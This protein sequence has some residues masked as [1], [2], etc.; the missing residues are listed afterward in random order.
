[1][2]KQVTPLFEYYRNITK[3]WTEI[4]SGLMVQ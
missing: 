4:P 2:K 3:N 1:M